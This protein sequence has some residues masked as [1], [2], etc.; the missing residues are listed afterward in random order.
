[1]ADLATFIPTRHQPPGRSRRSRPS[2]P[3]RR[4]ESEISTEDAATILLRYENGARGSV[5]VSQISP[6]R[7]N[8]LQYEIDG[9]AAAA[10]WDSEQPDQLWI[11]HRDRPNEILIRNPAL[12]NAGRAGRRGLPG[13]PRRGLRGHVHGALP[14][15]L[16]RRR[17]WRPGRFRYATFADGHEEMLVG[18]A[19]AQ[20]AEG[21]WADVEPRAGRTTDGRS[22]Q[23]PR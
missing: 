21:R 16:R 9:S 10:S 2:A 11:G 4:V 3:R 7:K 8:S 17:Q 20:R 22:R 15:D 12:M 18:D 14:R 1:M 23:A 13:R 6:G 19:I 5:A